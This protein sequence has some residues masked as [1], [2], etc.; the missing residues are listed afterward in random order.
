M[1]A[2][3]LRSLSAQ[4]IALGFDPLVESQL[5]CHICFAP[6]QF[7]LSFAAVSGVDQVSFSVRIERDEQGIY[8]LKYYAALLRKRVEVP[9]ELLAL[10]ERMAAVDWAAV[11]MGRQMA[12]QV[13]DAMVLEAEAVLQALQ[14]AGLGADLL[15]YKYWMGTSLEPL[16]L[17]ASL[18][19]SIWEISERFYFFPELEMIRFSDAIRFLNSRWMERQL[20]A[21]KKLLER[22]T[23]A[24]GGNSGRNLIIKKQQRVN[25]KK[26]LLKK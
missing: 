24:G 4:L 9:S 13:D 11:A 10:D 15:R 16:I 3:H 20:L 19:R 26:N 1:Q 12:K 17:H 22:A 14:D 18:H 21:K 6:S 2:A 8:Q 7:D 23:E 5:R 25:A